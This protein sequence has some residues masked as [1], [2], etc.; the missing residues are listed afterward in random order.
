MLGRTLFR[1]AGFLCLSLACC[2]LIA[3]EEEEAGDPAEVTIGERLFLET[4]FAQF[5][6]ANSNGDVNAPL[7]KG[8]P[9]V[10]FLQTLNGPIPSPMAGQ[11]MNCRQCH[12]VDDAKLTPGGGNRTYSDFARRSAIPAREDGLTLTARNSPALV[13][14]QLPRKGGFFLHFDAEFPTIKELVKA[15]LTGRNYGWLPTERAQAVKHIANVIRRDNGNNDLS[16]SFGGPYRLILKGEGQGIGDDFKLEGKFA[17]DVGRASDEQI[18]DLVGTLISEYLKTLT[19]GMDDAGNFSASAYDLFLKKNKLP[20][21]PRGRETDKAYGKR[22][23]E[24]LIALPSP[25]FVTPADGTLL[26]HPNQPF[27]FGADELAGLKLFLSEPNGSAPL[28]SVG[29]CIACHAPPRFTD[30][31]FH[32]TGATQ[33]E[34]DAIHGQ[35]AFVAL[36]I[37]TAAERAA[38]PAAF[39]PATANTPTGTGRFAAVPTLANPQLVDLGVWNVVG[40][41]DQ[42]RV[43]KFLQKAL[44]RADERRV[45]VETLV[46]RSIAVFKT[47]GL[48]DLG[49]S[50]PYFHTGRSDTLEESVGFYARFSQLVRDG[51]VRNADVD[52]GRI[53]ITPQDAGLIA[54]FLRSLNE[55]YE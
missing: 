47:P 31:N 37:P 42:A 34:Y 9:A 38:N 51:K 18:L 21:K 54:K 13:N 49:H 17:L 22:L 48:R 35:G 25:V 45:P 50:Q 53:T 2:G 52:I 8:D 46:D 27:A 30:F 23:L 15:T 44:L 32:N 36:A 41:A 55:D 20:Q 5:F 43:Q 14:A 29:N 39:L 28:S 4:R 12:L 3:G 24:A 33:D 40:N 26:L 10:E 1:A 19:F 7:A 6:F 16:R 11:S